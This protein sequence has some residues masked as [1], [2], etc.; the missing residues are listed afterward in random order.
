MAT[1]R[2]RKAQRSDLNAAN[3]DVRREEVATD[4]EV[5]ARFDA[6]SG[7][8]ETGDGLDEYQE[9]ARHGAEDVPANERRKKLSDI[10]VFDRAETEPKV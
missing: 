6:G 10:P 1:A 9:A 2:K 8:T 5:P 3:D 7:E 4:G